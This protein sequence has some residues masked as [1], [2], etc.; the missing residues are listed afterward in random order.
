MSQADELPNINLRSVWE[1]IRGYNVSFVMISSRPRLCQ[2][3]VCTYGRERF[4][5]LAQLIMSSFVNYSPRTCIGCFLNRVFVAHY[6]T[7][8]LIVTTAVMSCTEK[9]RL[10]ATFHCLSTATTMQ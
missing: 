10:R 2:R 9:P 4:P 3:C 6:R 7:R 8:A 5:C 1:L